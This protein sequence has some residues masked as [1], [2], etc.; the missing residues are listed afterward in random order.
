MAIKLFAFLGQSK[1][2]LN[3]DFQ[4]CFNDAGERNPDP[5]AGL[6]VKDHLVTIDA[7]DSSAKVALATHRIARFDLRR[8]ARKP[9][10]IGGP[11]KSAL[12]T[13]RRN[14]QRVRRVDEI[15]DVE[16]CAKLS[17]AVGAIPVPHPSRLTY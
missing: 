5:A 12:Q 15:F 7:D 6:V 8:A 9:F 4:I 10:V 1:L 11:V 16:G 3:V 17:A 14:L 13:W 2:S